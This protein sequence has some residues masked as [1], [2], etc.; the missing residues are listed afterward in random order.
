MGDVREKMAAAIFYAVAHEVSAQSAF[1]WAVSH[2]TITSRVGA[3]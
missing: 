2:F 1:I 3:E